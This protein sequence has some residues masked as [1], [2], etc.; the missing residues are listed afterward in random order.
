MDSDLRL[1][2]DYSGGSPEFSPGCSCL[3]STN[4]SIPEGRAINHPPLQIFPADLVVWMPSVFFFMVATFLSLTSWPMEGKSYNS[5]VNLGLD[6]HYIDCT[7][8]TNPSHMHTLHT[9]SL[10]LRKA[11]A[12][13]EHLSSKILFLRVVWT[14][15]LSYL[16][17]QCRTRLLG[18][19]RHKRKH[20]IITDDEN[21]WLFLI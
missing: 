20:A 11:K 3:T 15:W 8:L 9:V 2:R 19:H 1:P 6:S 7:I 17:C 18:P 13:A 4:Y 14:V 16:G 10:L 21:S 5:S 12:M